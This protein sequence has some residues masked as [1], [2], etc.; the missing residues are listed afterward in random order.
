MIHL[1]LQNNWLLLS[2]K[3]LF[4]QYFMRLLVLN[5]WNRF[6]FWVNSLQLSSRVW[7]KLSNACELHEVFAQ[8]AHSTLI[9]CAFPCQRRRPLRILA[10]NV[11]CEAVSWVGHGWYSGCFTQN[12]KEFQVLKRITYAKFRNCN[13]KSNLVKRIRYRNFYEFG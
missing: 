13:F 7:K 10:R 9:R 8:Q 5:C 6:C 11:T 3:F 12:I 4:Q 2:S 1:R